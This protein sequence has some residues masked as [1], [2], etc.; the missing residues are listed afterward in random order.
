MAQACLLSEKNKGAI[1]N[2]GSK[3]SLTGQGEPLLML[4]HAVEEMPLLGSGQ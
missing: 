4:P 2:I 1:V 3:V